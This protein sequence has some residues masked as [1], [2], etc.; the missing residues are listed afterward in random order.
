MRYEWDETKRLANIA[1][2]G[3]DFHEIWDFDWDTS[4]KEESPRA[5]EARYRAYGFIGVRLYS[6]VYTGR[7][8]N[9]R[10]ISLRKANDRELDRYATT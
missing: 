9:I 8:E 4:L 7:G 5:G 10:I 2:Y 1:K 6:V 3:V